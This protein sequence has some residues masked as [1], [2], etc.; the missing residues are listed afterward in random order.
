M[1]IMAIVSYEFYTNSYM[2]EPV[3]NTDF[4]RYDLRAES[5]I[6][7]ITKG[8]T[9]RFESFPENIQEAIKNAIC[10]QI[11]YFGIYG[12]EIAI[13]GKQDSG[14]TVGKVSVTSGASAKAGA[15]AMVSPL[16][17]SFLE[18]TGLLGPQVETAREPYWGWV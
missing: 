18:Q 13:T 6:R 15:S 12:L 3:E 11:E 16:V 8:A 4:P 5:L 2:G 17:I 10:A 7:S 14:F 1:I 9:D